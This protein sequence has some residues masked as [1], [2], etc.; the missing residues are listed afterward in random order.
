MTKVKQRTVSINGSIKTKEIDNER[1]IVFVASSATV[2][3]HYEQVN[4]ASLR[5]P[6]KGGGDI[7]VEAIPEEGVSKIIDIPLMLNHS[8]DVRDV[9]GSVRTAYHQGGELIFECGVS[10]RDV[11]QEM[12]QLIEEGHLSNAFSITMFDYDYDFETETISNAEVI[13]VSLVYRG[14]NKDARLVAIKSLIETGEE[15]PGKSKQND[16]FGSANG[17]GIDHNDDHIQSEAPQEGEATEP[18]QTTENNGDNEPEAPVTNQDDNPEEGD[19]HKNKNIK[20]AQDTVAKGAQPVQPVGVSDY[21]KSKAAL[22]D[23]KNIVL[24]HHRGS[25]ADIMREWTDNLKSKGIT[26]DAIMPSAIEN[27]FFKAWID[28]PG[29]LATFRQVGARSGSVNAF[30]TEDTALGHKKGEAKKKQTLKNVRR[31]IKAKAI[32]KRLDIDLQD[33]FDDET[34][35]LLK[36]RVE[37][38]T[39]R[40]SNAIAVGALLAAGTGN[41]ATLEGTR[42][43][44]PMVADAKDTSGFGS[45]VAE[46]IDVA[47]GKSEY[48]IAIE[49]VES[50]KDSLGQGKILIVPEGF[51]KAIRL[52]KDSEGRPLF[53]VGMKIE[54]LLGVKAIFEVPE[55][56]SIDSG[57][58]KAIAYADQSYVLFGEPTASVR[59]DFNL[60]NNQDVMLVERYVGG[61]AQGHKTLA[62]AIEA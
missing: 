15:M 20:I 41:D 19:M 14:S 3:R 18:E 34:G 50:V 59:T 29:I 56:A 7:T 8:G 36:F 9:I 13:E 39:A 31:D 32:Y 17:D 58:V 37:E 45:L 44:Y 55:M 30:S 35:E 5:L 10:N 6:L 60:D 62:V 52:E 53:P 42:G 43:L 27:I 22:V 54:E 38:L 48:D 4:V 25:N 24:K 40:V 46:K 2:D 47:S 51:R 12:L 23:F 57:K 28:N 49:T 11:A 26:G 21:L 1:R 16:T 33:L 61:S